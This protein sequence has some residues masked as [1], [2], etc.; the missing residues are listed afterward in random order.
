M[1]YETMVTLARVIQHYCNREVSPE[2][3]DPSTSNQNVHCQNTHNNR[4]YYLPYTDSMNSTTHG[5]K[6][7]ILQF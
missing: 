3:I 7:S 6:L 4:G 1:C 5:K 2:K